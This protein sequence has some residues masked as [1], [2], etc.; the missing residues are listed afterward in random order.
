MY[1][2]VLNKM[3]KMYCGDDYSDKCY[4]N[5]EQKKGYKENDILGGM[6]L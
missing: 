5:V 6:I 1:L 2:S 4:K 3:E